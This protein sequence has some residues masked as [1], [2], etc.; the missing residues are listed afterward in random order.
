MEY[1]SLEEDGS[2]GMFLTQNSSQNVH[3]K[4]DKS[5][6]ETDM[7]C[8]VAVTDFQSPCGSMLRS[9]MNDYSDISDE[10]EVFGKPK[11]R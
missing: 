7:F 2:E 10:E 5:D 11:F 6:G 4:G 8:G 3:N 9:N 1:Y